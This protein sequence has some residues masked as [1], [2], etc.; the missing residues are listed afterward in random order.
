MTSVDTELSWSVEE[1]VLGDYCDS[2]AY[3]TRPLF[4][5]DSTALQVQLYYDDLEAVTYVQHAQNTYIQFFT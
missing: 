4:Q 3:K 2:Q 1:G 5:E